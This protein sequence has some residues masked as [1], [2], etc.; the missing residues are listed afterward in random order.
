MLLAL[1]RLQ[2]FYFRFR[3]CYRKSI[4]YGSLAH[5]TNQGLAPIRTTPKAFPSN[6]CQNTN[7][8]LKT[9]PVNP[10]KPNTTEKEI[11]LYHLQQYLLRLTN[12]KTNAQGH[13]NGNNSLC[14]SIRRSADLHRNRGFRNCNTKSC[15]SNNRERG[16]LR[17]L[18]QHQEKIIT[19]HILSSHNTFDLSTVNRI[20]PNTGQSI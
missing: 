20:P 19:S 3:G 4:L 6:N 7:P 11:L 8:A 1:G 18:L 5:V 10:S 16:I 9:N 14:H 15:S 17:C 13:S 12:E 2:N